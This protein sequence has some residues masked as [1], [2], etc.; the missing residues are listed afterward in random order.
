[1][2]DHD[3]TN[4]LIIPREKAIEFINKANNIS[5][6]ICPCRSKN[7]KCPED[8][9]EVC[10][11]F[12]HAL[13]KHLKQAIPIDKTIALSIIQKAKKRKNLC[14]VFFIK[15]TYQITEICNCCSCC[16]IPNL[17][18][19]NQGEYN[20]NLRISCL[21]ATDTNLCDLCAKCE[22]ICFFEARKIRD[23]IL[24]FNEK[25][26]YGCGLCVENCPM[27]AISLVKNKEHGIPIPN[28]I[29]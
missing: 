28:I 9:W 27:K 25:K 17:Q 26:C 16:C 18:I 22:E 15:K 6:R 8:T 19:I 4:S 14:R 3:K 24:T 29:V 21:A 11:L 13:K 20:N 7:Q 2:C 5:L 1:M 23:G 12:E 10:I